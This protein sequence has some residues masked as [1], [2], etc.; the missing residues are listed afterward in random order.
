MLKGGVIG[1]GGVGR[2]MTNKLHEWGIAEIVGACNRG[3]DKLEIAKKEYGLKTTHDPRELCSWDLD[4]VLVTSTSYAHPEHVL[5]GAE[6]G[7]HMLIEKPVALNLEDADKM[8]DACEAKDLITVVNYTRRFQPQFQRMKEI[9]DDGE[10][11]EVLSVT[12]YVA[13]GFGLYS[14]GARHRAVVEAD[15]SGGWLVH[16]ACHQIDLSLI[17]I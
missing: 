2:N 9:V 4:F 7:L 11:G 3:A 12:S 10:L 8:Q 6:A 1:F 15:E 16:H 17:H 14:S 5:A 13:R